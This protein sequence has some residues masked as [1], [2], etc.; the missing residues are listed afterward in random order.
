MPLDTMQNNPLTLQQDICVTGEEKNFL[1][2]TNSKNYIIVVV[3]FTEF[4]RLD[5]T[6]CIK[7][8]LRLGLRS[9]II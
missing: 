1:Q 6:I 7:V 9:I 4:G 3:S 5:K 8:S 2:K